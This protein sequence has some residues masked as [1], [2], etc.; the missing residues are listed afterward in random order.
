[1]TEP[2]ASQELI[3]HDLFG[4]TA[5]KRKLLKDEA[6]EP[7]SENFDRGTREAHDGQ[8]DSLQRHAA[9]TAILRNTPAP[10]CADG[11]RHA[12]KL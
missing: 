7:L 9:G 3:P 6:D 8:S 1:M 10:T 12:A 4:R 2:C 5:D 11:T